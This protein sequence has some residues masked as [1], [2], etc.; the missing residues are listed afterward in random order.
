MMNISAGLL[1][2]KIIDNTPF[3]FLGKQG[4][5]Y[6]ENKEHSWSIPKGHVNDGETLLETAIREFKE[7]TNIEP[8]GPYLELSPIKTKKKD[9]IVHIFAFNKN[10]NKKDEPFGCNIITVEYK[11]KKYKVPEMSDGK[12]FTYLEA[13]ENIVKYQIPIIEE[14]DIKLTSNI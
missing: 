12:Y 14:L 5:P 3:Y 8:I 6:W 7:E 1:M 11:G 13:I 4:G 10:W 2:Y 9:K